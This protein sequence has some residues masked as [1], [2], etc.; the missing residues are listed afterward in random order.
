MDESYVDGVVGHSDAGLM[1]D[2]CFVITKESMAE[3]NEK[4]GE[5]NIAT[6]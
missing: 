4:G 3:R 2:P 5:E 1:N 6:G